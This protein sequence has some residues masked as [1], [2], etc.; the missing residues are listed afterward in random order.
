MI[1]K[2]NTS[3]KVSVTFVYALFV[4]QVT[5]LVIGMI[6]FSDAAVIKNSEEILS[7]EK[8]S[9]ITFIS[10]WINKYIFTESFFSQE[11]AAKINILL[12]IFFFQNP[13]QNFTVSF[14]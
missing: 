5:F 11:L 14:G 6:S 7:R 9:S 2:E 8:R 12:F 3:L 1:F 10:Y 4:P 13:G